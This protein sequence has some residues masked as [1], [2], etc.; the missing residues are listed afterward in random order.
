MGNAA[1]VSGEKNMLTTFPAQALPCSGSTGIISADKPVGDQHPE[2]SD[3][4]VNRHED[5][6]Y[7]IF[8]L[9][10]VTFAGWQSFNLI[11]YIK[12]IPCICK[13]YS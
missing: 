6:T 12:T 5:K 10:S 7:F 13:K 1:E 11:V 9:N 4:T 3:K 2:E 8:F